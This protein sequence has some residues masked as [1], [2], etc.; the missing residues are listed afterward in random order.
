MAVC[1]FSIWFDSVP[2][3]QHL[4]T[5]CCPSPAAA[6]TIGGIT[7]VASPDLNE[8]R[9]NEGP[10]SALAISWRQTQPDAGKAGVIWVYRYYTGDADGSREEVCV[11]Y[12][13]PAALEDTSRANSDAPLELLVPTC[14]GNEKQLAPGRWVGATGAWAECQR[15]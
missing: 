7:S 11:G 10:I 3:S 12:V 5:A 1:T 6:G 14:P 4:S 15:R 2:R 13:A 9:V 8:D